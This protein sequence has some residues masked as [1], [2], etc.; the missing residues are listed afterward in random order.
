M[1]PQV[2]DAVAERKSSAEPGCGGAWWVI[3]ALLAA[4]ADPA[5]APVERAPTEA[6]PLRP[7][8][9]YP[10]SANGHYC[11]AVTTMRFR[12]GE[13]I[14]ERERLATLDLGLSA[15]APG[16]M[17]ANIEG[18]PFVVMRDP[19]PD[20]ATFA[21][22]AAVCGQSIYQEGRLTLRHEELEHELIFRTLPDGRAVAARPGEG[23][24]FTTTQWA[25]AQIEGE[26]R[27]HHHGHP[28]EL[29]R[30]IHTYDCSRET[31]CAR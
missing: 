7:V 9:S 6:P 3:L 12:D 11:C 28:P 18:C 10:E 13:A 20:E 17:V 23:D 8:E 4:C 5:A 21:L 24:R 30:A 16:V 19:L 29:V 15:H 22:G 2:Q 31:R 14:W 27:V 1:E 26:Q 25:S